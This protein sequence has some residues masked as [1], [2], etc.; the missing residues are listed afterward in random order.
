MHLGKLYGRSLSLLTDLYQLTMAAGYHGQDMVET[1][2]VFHLFYRSNPFDGGYAVAAGIDTAVEFLSGLSFDENDIEYL[3]GME[4]NDGSPLFRRWFLEYL[5]DFKFKCDVEAVAEGTIVFPH[6]PIVK[7]TGPLIQCQ[8]VET[9][10]LNI[11][12]FQTLIAT[13]AHRICRAAQGDPVLEF[14]LRRAQG[15]DGGVMAARAAYIGGCVGTSNV[16]AGEML[17]IPVKGTHAHS[18]VMAFDSESE[19]FERYAQEMPNNCVFLV[20]TY[21]TVEGVKNAIEVSRDLR[22]RGHEPVGIRLDSGDLCYLSKKARE[23][24]DEAGFEDVKIVASNSL[25]EHVIQSLKNQ[26]AKIDLWGVGTRLAT[27]YDQPALGGV[28]KLA[29]ISEDGEDWTPKIKLSEQRIKISNPGSIC[30]RRYTGRDGM[31]MGDMLYNEHEGT[32]ES[33][34]IVDPMDDT[35]RKLVGGFQSWQKLHESFMVEGERTGEPSSLEAIRAHRQR[36]ESSVHSSIMRLKNPH[37]YPV[38]L[39]KKLHKHRTQLILEARGH[40]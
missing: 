23:L 9:A 18:W 34:E 16:L 11:V 24:L 26:G 19:A 14:G 8:L 7:V 2:S 15:I 28:Y 20:D 5:S 37:E 1:Q 32:P 13:K 3:R 25:D 39:S 10:L 29:A 21:D 27:A 31:Y 6:E 30:I 38:G 12:N 33:Y 40:E 17:D 22:D 4:G 35:R 36:S